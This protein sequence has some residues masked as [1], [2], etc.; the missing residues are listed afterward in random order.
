MPGL[1]KVLCI[2]GGGIRGLIPALVLAAI[3]KRTGKKS[4][5][6][7]DMIAGT[8]TGGI[9]ALGLTRPGPGGQPQYKAEDLAEI[10]E[11]DGPKIFSR[12]LWHRFRAIGNLAEEKYPHSGIESVLKQYFGEA[13]LKD[14]LRDVLL[15]AY[16]IERRVPWFFRSRRARVDPEY[17]FP[18]WQVARATSAAPTYF[19]PAQLLTED[20]TGYFALVDG[21]VFANN[22]A[23]CAYV[24]AT[25]AHPGA[26]I[27]M[28]SLGT[29]EL[30]RAYP[31]HEAKT[32]GLAKWA[33][34]VLD[35]MFD[36]VSK[37]VEYQLD[38]LLPP[39]GGRARYYRFQTTLTIA[40]DNMDDA[41]A[42]NL[43]KLRL[44]AEGLIRSASHQIDALCQELT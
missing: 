25:T 35:L 11:N 10:Y 41:T 38:Q 22:P 34:P 43:H 24:D 31:F 7:F 23:M 33:Q 1:V 2:D 8:S 9:L 5:E 19:E 37:T 21:G 16:E 28:V 29:G 15:T 18:V 12:D 30:T 4:A 3:E 42:D 44:Q 20:I 40:S 32:W 13:R 6:L 26:E 39:A 36:G 17:D 27:L 14:A